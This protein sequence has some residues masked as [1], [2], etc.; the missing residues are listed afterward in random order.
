MYVPRKS[1]AACGNRNSLR[2]TI[3]FWPIGRKEEKVRARAR[4][5][6]KSDCR[7]RGR[8][9]EEEVARLSNFSGLLFLSAAAA[10][11]VLKSGS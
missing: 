4:A 10:A 5:R 2:R 8:Y 7:K 1:N 9:R 6:A 3:R 11:A